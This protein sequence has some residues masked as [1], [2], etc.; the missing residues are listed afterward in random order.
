MARRAPR[1]YRLLLHLLPRDARARDRQELEAA[2]AACVERERQQFGFAGAAW[3]WIRAVADILIAAV[4][5]RADERNRRHI[6]ALRQPQP[7]TGDTV[8][9][10]FWQDVRYAV[11][12]MR[13]APGFSAVVILTLALAIGVNTAIFSVVDGVLLRSLPFREPNRLVM[14]YEGWKGGSEPIGFSAPDFKAIEARQQAFEGVAAFGGRQFELSGIDQPERVNALRVSAALF[15]VLGVRPALGRTFTRAEDDGRIPVAMLTDG[16][17]RRR[18]GADPAI[19]GRSISLD[20]RAYTVVGVMPPQ[21][22]FPNRG[23]VLNNIPADLYVPISFTQRELLGFGSMYNKSVVARLK[24]GVTVG[25]ADAEMRTLAPRVGEDLYPA[26]LK[27]LGRALSAS[28]TP[29]RDETVGRIQTILLVLMTAAGVV[30]L[31]ACADIA[32][33]MLTRAAIRAREMAVRSALGA[34]RGKLVRQVLVEAAVLSA[35]GALIGVVFAYWAAAVLVRLA[36][37]TIPRLHEVGI[38]VRAL[39]FALALAA[40]TALLCGLLPALE[41]T[42]R[43]SGES[44][45]EGG[46]GGTSGIR[47]RRIFGT[48]VTAQ[49]ALAVVLLVAGGLLMRSFAR[50]MAVDPGFRTER[51]LTMA[52]SLPATAYPR[53][54]NVRGFYQS[55]IERV[56][57]LPGV[58]ATGTAVD[59]PLSTRERRV[60]MIE[61]QPAE[62]AKLPRVVAHDWI[63]GRYFE[64]MGIALRRGR[65]P[66]PEDH[67]QSEAVVVINETMARQFW[68]NQDPLGQRIAWGMPSDHGPWMRIVGIVADVKQ[69]P[70]NTETVAQ[71]YL[72]SAQVADAMVADNVWGGLRS[73]KVIV[74]GQADPLALTA[75]VTA[76]VREL[77]P[78]LPLAQVRT[79]EEVVSESAGPHRFNTVLLGSFAATALVLAALGIAGVLATSVSRRTQELG[80]RMALGAQRSD[81]LRMV[82]RQGMTLAILGVALGVPAAL[83]LTKLLS[84]LLF[85][86]SPYDPATFV[87]VAT[88]LLAVALAACYVPARRATRVDPIVALRYE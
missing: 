18:F 37:P 6:V 58:A 82:I 30:L 40:I 16:L 36:P 12:T 32:N 50:L 78:A 27:E 86:V 24:P 2:F 33:L 66:G 76:Q 11:R 14:L 10:S 48:L 49:F 26:E 80:V 64:A 13:S 4:L 22:L 51:V 17:W 19:V 70:L 61:V 81:V 57:R 31:I 68:P 34:G 60:F 53:A 55:L 71:T 23:P 9:M 52:T 88:V 39:G 59:L 77:D 1:A 44:L 72:P 67:A 84:S 5:L 21:F 63:G 47:Q 73:L 8:M 7:N 3:A 79:M 85:Q 74:R 42:R 38:D 43:P 45:K 29:L 54:A 83:A 69:G 15:D 28:A 35:A 41:L 20:R 87:L 75:A 46:R 25:A 65:Y 62:S 56:D